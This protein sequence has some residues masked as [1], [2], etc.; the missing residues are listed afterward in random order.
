MDFL[1]RVYEFLFHPENNCQTIEEV[2]CNN[3]SG[4]CRTSEIQKVAT[5][6]RTK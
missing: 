2:C 4:D 1:L 5:D 6:W 3:T